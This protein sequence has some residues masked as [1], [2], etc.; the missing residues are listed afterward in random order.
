VAEK[1]RI[2]FDPRAELE[3]LKVEQKF[4]SLSRGI[5]FVVSVL[6]P[7]N[8]PLLAP[9]T[10]EDPIDKTAITY[11]VTKAISRLDE[12]TYAYNGVPYLWNGSKWC[13]ADGWL[14]ALSHSFHGALRTGE[15][16]TKSSRCFYS[17]LY[18]AWLASHRQ[19]LQLS[20][21]GVSGGI[22]LQNGVLNLYPREYVMRMTAD[23]RKKIGPVMGFDAEGEVS[24][25]EAGLCPHDPGRDI[26]NGVGFSPSDGNV[27]TL[28]AEVTAT[29][30]ALYE[31]QAGM[32]KDSLLMRFLNASLDRDQQSIV[33]QWFGYH[34]VLHRIPKQEKMVY[35]Y[36]RGENGK[37]MLVNLLR[38]LITDDAVA[39]LSLRDL[40]NS[41]SIESLAGK[42]AM[43]G[44]EG[45]PETDNELLKSIVSWEPLHVN[46]KYRDPFELKPTCL[47]TQAS[48]FKPEFKDDSDAMV[49]R[50]IAIEMKFQ[51]TDSTRILDVASKILREEYVLLVAWALLGAQEVLRHGALVVPQAI[52]E[53]SER[54]VRP[55]RGI[56][57]LMSQFEFGNFE[58]SEDELY[59]AYLVSS[60]KQG[61]RIEPRKEFFDG[62][63]TR[64]ERTGNLYLRRT[65]VV[66]YVPS[67]HIN[68][69]GQQIALCP[70]LVGAKDTNVFFGFRI[71]E[72]DFGPAIGHPIPREGEFKRRGVPNFEI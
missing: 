46:P 16:T 42:A 53:H 26:L 38:G 56:D 24:E 66:G 29:F 36:G 54:V 48:N 22:P 18:A 55:I 10:I 30:T 62:L 7:D 41:S 15:L 1:S 64:L 59:A 45:T 61:V 8:S 51:A 72:G 67:M 35:L 31:L 2:P 32:H 69:F 43:I 58:V 70:Q 50:V 47:V 33:Q 21:F 68:D 3:H 5:D 28:P 65:K 57:R 63:N 71:Q 6:K 52:R 13:P 20:P 27:H 4:S 39:T 23:E 37:G 11:A 25:G 60:K 9:I 40:K 19:P 34:L 44:S 14:R 17:S 49:R 12:F